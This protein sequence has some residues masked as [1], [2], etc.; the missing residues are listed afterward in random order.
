MVWKIV[1]DLIGREE[2]RTIATDENERESENPTSAT[3]ATMTRYRIPK[4]AAVVGLVVEMVVDNRD[5]KVNRGGGMVEAVEAVMPVATMLQT[6]TEWIGITGA[7][8]GTGRVIETTI[9]AVGRG[10]KSTVE[11][12]DEGDRYTAW[13][14]GVPPFWA[15]ST[16]IGMVQKLSDIEWSLFMGLT[17]PLNIFVLIGSQPKEEEN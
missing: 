2:E 8:M 17:I 4:R 3:T 5:A 7:Q 10:K 16:D 1:I 13:W 9:R 11:E 15:L 6:V 14:K 12:K